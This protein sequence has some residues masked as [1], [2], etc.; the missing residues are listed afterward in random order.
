MLVE[1]QELDQQEMLEETQVR[2]PKEM[3]VATPALHQETLR[4]TLLA[5]TP[6]ALEEGLRY[7][8]RAHL[9]QVKSLLLQDKM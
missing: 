1:T 8:L 2:H 5:P 7:H 3:L 4:V 9:L 6:Q